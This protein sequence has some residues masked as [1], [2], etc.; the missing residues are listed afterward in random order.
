MK[1]FS[2]LKF[3]HLIYFQDKLFLVKIWI[4]KNS[5]IYLFLINIYNFF[6]KII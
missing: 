6:K 4:I 2:E 1:S 5:F 3:N